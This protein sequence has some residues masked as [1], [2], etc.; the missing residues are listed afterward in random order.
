MTGRDVCEVYWIHL[1]SHKDI[2]SEGYVGIS[3]KGA[4]R[5]FIEHKSAVNSGSTLT[6]HNAIRKH[7]SD[8]IVDTVLI[9]TS[10][11][12]LDVES[13]LRP[14]PNIGWN[15]SPGGALTRLGV[16]LSDESKK[17]IS[18]NNGQRGRVYTDEERLTM[19]IKAKELDFKHTEEM[20]QHLKLT[21]LERIKADNGKQ[22][23]SAIQAAAEKNK[24][25][26]RWKRPNAK[27]AVWLL[28]D[29]IYT[30]MLENE[31]FGQRKIARILGLNYSEIFCIFRDIKTGW[32]PCKD[33]EWVN[34]KLK[35]K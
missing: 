24:D 9:G 19:S 13:K 4:Q 14:T 3:V 22:I 29:D 6:V 18:L 12:C 34:F 28:A 11:Y 5:R 16:K 20:K 33:P 26:L 30:T 17:K 25:L 32:I 8:I 15:I 7:S 10:D 21:A 23:A 35:V 31:T 2:F 1:E 27:Q